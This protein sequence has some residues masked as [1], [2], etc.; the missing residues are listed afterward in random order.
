MA[1]KPRLLTKLVSDPTS[2]HGTSSCRSVIGSWQNLAILRGGTILSI[3]TLQ[4][5]RPAAS[6]SMCSISKRTNG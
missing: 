5:R 2:P 6:R 1:I 4:R 3:A